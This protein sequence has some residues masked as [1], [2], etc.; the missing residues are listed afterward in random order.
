MSSKLFS[1]DEQ[2]DWAQLWVM[3][4]KEEHAE[5]NK[6]DVERAWHS[7]QFLGSVSKYVCGPAPATTRYKN[8]NN[9]WAHHTFRKSLECDAAPGAHVYQ[10]T[11]KA[12]VLAEQE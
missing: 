1:A 11:A 2:Y 12:R 7:S 9:T 10:D 8:T 5:L 3:S 4:I 6:G